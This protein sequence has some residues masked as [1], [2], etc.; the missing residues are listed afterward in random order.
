[1]QTRTKPSIVTEKGTLTKEHSVNID[2]VVEIP[3]SVDAKKFFDDLLDKIIEY[4]EASGG[5]AG[6][7]MAHN[8]YQSED[9]E[10]PDDRK[11]T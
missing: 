4:V 2:G 9:N 10:G 7:S 5:S 1:M 11:T 6:L 8:K 3:N